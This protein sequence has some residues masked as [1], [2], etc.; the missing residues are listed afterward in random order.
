VETGQFPRKRKMK[1]ETYSLACLKQ[2]ERSIDTLICF[3]KKMN[4]ELLV[5]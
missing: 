4:R 5:V 3:K 1:E 2:K